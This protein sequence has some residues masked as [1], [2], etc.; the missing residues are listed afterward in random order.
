[1]TRRCFFLCRERIINYRSKSLK[2]TQKKDLPSRSSTVRPWKV[3]QNPIGRPDRLPTSHHFSG[4]NSL[5]NFGS[6]SWRSWWKLAAKGLWCDRCQEDWF[7]I[8]VSVMCMKKANLHI[9]TVYIWY[10][11]IYICLYMFLFIHISHIYIY[12]IYLY[13]HIHLHANCCFFPFT[14]V[15]FK[16]SRTWRASWKKSFQIWAILGTPLQKLLRTLS[17][18]A[19]TFE[20]GKSVNLFLGIWESMKSICFLSFGYEN[21]QNWMDMMCFFSCF[22]WCWGGV[23]VD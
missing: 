14:F 12:C 7:H 21:L 3:T 10:V 18:V 4:V 20:A 5:L 16:S 2:N 15:A 11:S 6:V 23:K 8:L 19:S 17:R 9:N 22:F 1:M 13:R